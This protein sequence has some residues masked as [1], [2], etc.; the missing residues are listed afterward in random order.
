MLFAS[1]IAL[2][3]AA[4]PPEQTPT[5]KEQL[6]EHVREIVKESRAP[7]EKALKQL[8]EL[9]TKENFKSLGFDSLEELP[10]AELGRPLPVL[11]VRLDELREYK[12][13]GDAYKLLHPIPKV[14]YGVN[15]K[16]EPRCGVEVQKRDGKWEASAI[17]IAGPA[18]QYVQAVK[19]QAEKDRGTV[20]FL[21]KVLALNETY[22]GYQ[23]DQGVKLVHVRQQAEEKDKVEARPAA[24]VFAELV[25]RAK[26]HDGKLR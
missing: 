26:E 1:A 21:V 16:G 6:A 7:A 24:D 25:K 5:T 11:M 2:V 8:R 10:S 15:V 14:V 9:A 17:G 13:K 12:P 18:R 22:L 20:F 19:R 23:T 3:L 4:A